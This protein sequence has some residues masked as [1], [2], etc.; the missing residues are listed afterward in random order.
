MTKK[1]NISL[2]GRLAELIDENNI[3]LSKFVQKA[4][5]KEFEIPE[6]KKERDKKDKRRYNRAEPFT[7]SLPD[8]LVKEL[9]KREISLSKFVQRKL[10]PK[11]GIY[12]KEEQEENINELLKGMIKKS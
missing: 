3:S 11:F 5:R 12:T 2:S 6:N 10:G 1:R 8:N 7:I 4:L 9:D